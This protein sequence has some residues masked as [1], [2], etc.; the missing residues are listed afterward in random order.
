MDPLRLDRVRRP[1]NCDVGRDLR[2]LLRCG[3]QVRA[4]VGAVRRGVDTTRPLA[5]NS[6][7]RCARR[8]RPRFELC[9]SQQA[10]RALTSMLDVKRLLALLT[11]KN[12]TLIPL[13][14]L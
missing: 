6:R 5:R 9:E 13:A 2:R 4:A 12:S 3:G 11:L 8:I 10:S 7:A 14:T 1:A